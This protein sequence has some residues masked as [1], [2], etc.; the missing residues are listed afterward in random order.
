M[1][2]VFIEGEMDPKQELLQQLKKIISEHLGVEQKEVAEDSTWFQLGADSL[3]RLE[4]SLAIEEAFQVEIPY[5]VGEQLN[6]VGQTVEYLS[7]VI[8]ERRA[9]GTFRIEAATTSE[10]WTE[11]VEIR[12]RVFADECGFS[13][14][15]LPGL[16]EEGVWHFLA[17]DNRDAIGALSVVDTTGNCQIHRRYRLNFGENDRVARYAQLAI[18][19]PYRRCGVFKMLIDNAR[20]AVIRPNGFTVSWLV[21]PAARARSSILTRSLGFTAEAPLLN[22]EFGSCHVLVYRESTNRN[23]EFAPARVAAAAR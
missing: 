19:K 9:I 10:Q 12:T 23:E 3:D 17:R 22:T 11:M 21:Y 6:S 14:R 5:A 13:L 4:T 18:L 15:S 8:A 16:G 7:T 1:Q 2:S 20:N